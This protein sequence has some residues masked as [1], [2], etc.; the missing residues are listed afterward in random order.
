MNSSL[1]LPPQISPVI[2]HLFKGVLYDDQ[3]PLLWR[4]LLT[5]QAA[6]RDYFSIIGLDIFVDETENYAFVRQ[7]PENDNEDPDVPV[8]PRLIQRRPLSYPVSLLCILLR[9]KLIEADAEGAETR[10]ILSREQIIDMM[11]VLLAEKTNEAKVIE[12]ID[13]A[14]NKVIDYGLLRRLKDNENQ[15]EIRRIIKALVDADWLTN[16]EQKLQGYKD[17][18]RSCN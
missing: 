12:Q 6:V 17:H 9:K 2:I 1:N 18:A 16:I 5:F 15:F 10:V 8:L 7:S 4:D 14:T 3:Q 13:S 11:R